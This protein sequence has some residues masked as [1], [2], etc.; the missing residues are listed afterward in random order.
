MLRGNC[1]RCL[2]ELASPATDARTSPAGEPPP[3]R[4]FG[5]YELELELARGGMGIVYR[6]RQVSLN[7]PVALK[8][9]AAGQHAPSALVQRFRLEAEAVA[10]LSH[11]NIVS[12]HEVGEHE[13]Q[14]F[15][16]ME[17]V[18][19]GTLADR[20]SKDRPEAGFTVHTGVSV[21]IKV[22][23]AVHYAH[24]RGVLHRDLK[25][26]NVLMDAQGEPHITDF[27]VAKILE[28][29]IGLTQTSA[30]LGTPAY[31]AP[32]QAAGL[33]KQVTTATDIYGLGAILYELLTGAPP[34]RAATALETIRLVVEQEPARPRLLNPKI[35]SDLETICLKCLNK[36]PQR[37]YGSAELLADDLER[38][39][40]GEPI[41][42]RPVGAPEKFWSWCR[43]HPAVAS[44][45]AAVILLLAVVTLVSAF[46][47]VRLARSEQ[48]IT[49]QLWESYLQQARAGRLGGRPGRRFDSLTAI[50]KAAVLRPSIE[51]RNE[52]IASLA[53]L[54]LRIAR[55]WTVPAFTE[56]DVLCFD[57]KLEFY[58]RRNEA[59]DITIRRA[60]DN[61]EVCLAPCRDLKILRI[62]GFSPNGRYLAIRC[63]DE[64]NRVW[65]KEKREWAWDSFPGSAPVCFHPSGD[66][67]AN[68]NA[69]ATIS[70]FDLDS[71]R[72][73][74]RLST[75]ETPGGTMLFHPGGSQLARF[76]R[77]KSRLEVWDLGTQKIATSVSLPDV[78][79]ELAWSDDGRFLAA[80]CH[81]HCAYVL[82]AVDPGPLRVF[83]GHQS[84]VTHLGF[85]HA[86]DLLA[87]TG[88]DG[89][90]RLWDPLK[91][92]LLLT[93][94][95]AG[96]QVQFSADDSLL[97]CFVGRDNS[98]GLLEVSSSQTY[99]RL[100]TSI[101]TG[102]SHG[103]D[104]DPGE[105]LIVA[106]SHEGVFLM[107]ARTG[108]EIGFLREPGCDSVLFHPDG[109]SFFTSGDSG[110]WRWPLQRVRRGRIEEIRIGR[111][112]ALHPSVGRHPVFASRQSKDGRWVVAVD[113][114]V[115]PSGAKVLDLENP[116]RL[117]TLSHPNAAFL[118]LSP[119]GKYVATGTWKGNE[120]KIWESST[121]FLIRT[122]P[123]EGSR[124]V[125][126]SPDN[127]WLVT[128]GRN[129]LLFWEVGT[130]RLGTS[131]APIGINL[132]MAG[133]AFSPDSR[134]L[135]IAPDSRDILLLDS[136]T[137]R[138]VATLEAPY[139]VQVSALRFNR[140][141]SQLI[142][143]DVLNEV[144]I[145]DLRALRKRLR[146]LGL[147]W[148]LPTYP[149]APPPSDADPL[150]IKVMVP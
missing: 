117:L 99:R 48:R 77:G 126:F 15:Y 127:H 111:K 80:G 105:R 123:L 10:R 104:A 144:H 68:A 26:A 145:W 29:D 30:T 143:A 131:Y 91:A 40:R 57:Q 128:F 65:D 107:D 33:A 113:E 35:D 79:D 140:D 102:E 39:L 31:M 88:W 54:D 38:W 115:E 73:T 100:R 106:T 5:D 114:E 84:L 47:A 28:G 52:A 130:W 11:P 62:T 16:S 141:G 61:A 142:A 14:L 139:Q 98:F 18:E 76:D 7:R 112:S 17:L 132:P 56:P 95:G 116:D 110:L 71:R 12:I 27:G 72:E 46:A 149:P 146:E 136:Q 69:D 6:A 83:K 43:R 82:D 55:Q 41:L 97:G 118:A 75:G 124:S 19:G 23:R 119:N 133:S 36:E 85:N 66:T 67:F 42:A 9:I 13:G 109:N 138:S 64:L 81:D 24:Q 4:F 89:S 134:L 78:C 92:M 51:L 45:G 148:E 53:L 21:L 59:G 34:F 22:A 129:Q 37:R 121:G 86:G 90:I 147:D 3:L 50:K 108:R 87:T 20:I 93:Y 122:L 32:E 103:L 74:G 120:V 96:S 70:F 135:A 25:P 125:L 1:P 150:E 60:Q 8:M 137:A 58:A 2:L 101:R 63:Q 44:L 94:P 49:E